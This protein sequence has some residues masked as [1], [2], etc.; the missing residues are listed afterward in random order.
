M[1]LRFHH[2][3]LHEELHSLNEK[4]DKIISLLEASTSLNQEDESDELRSW[5]RRN[6]KYPNGFTFLCANKQATV[7]GA[8]CSHVLYKD[9]GQDDPYILYN[10]IIPA[11]YDDDEE[12]LVPEFI[13]DR[14]INESQ[15]ITA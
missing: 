8:I 2:Q 11:W 13:I 10:C 5:A 15:R 3:D 9:L 1:P 7:T 4:L 12:V 6:R 14:I